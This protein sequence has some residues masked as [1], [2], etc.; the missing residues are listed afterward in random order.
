MTGR[1]DH[2]RLSVSLSARLGLPD[3]S[4]L[5][6]R[7]ENLSCAGFQLM[8]GPS[9]VAC[10]FPVTRQPGPRERRQ[11][12]VLLGGGAEDALP[13]PVNAQCAAVFARR[14]AESAWQIGFEFLDPEPQL[15]DWL[16]ARIASALRRAGDGA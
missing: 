16:Q 12:D 7:T 2:P 13:I 5:E 3:G 10:L 6:G 9:A 14:T 11:A 15:L 1:R 4:T 8:S